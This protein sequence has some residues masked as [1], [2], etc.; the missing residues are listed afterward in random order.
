MNKLQFQKFYEW[1][2]NYTDTPSRRGSK[3]IFNL[4]RS[5][6]NYFLVCMYVFSYLLLVL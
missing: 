3:I 4:T 2:K 5:D 1:L 6:V